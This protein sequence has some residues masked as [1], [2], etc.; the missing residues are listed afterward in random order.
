MGEQKTVDPFERMEFYFETSQTPIAFVDSMSVAP[1]GFV[2]VGFAFVGG[3][4]VGVASVGISR[5][6]WLLLGPLPSV[7]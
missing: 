4:F 6:L 3:V 5:E 7:V 2:F 1:A